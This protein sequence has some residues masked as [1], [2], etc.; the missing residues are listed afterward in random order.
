MRR[1]LGDGHRRGGPGGLRLPAHAAAPPQQAPARAAAG[2]EAGCV[3]GAL[4]GVWAVPG[5][6]G[7]R[8]VFRAVLT[9]N[10]A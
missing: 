10:G 9:D 7:T 6:D 3:A 1:G 4:E 2:G 8:R 5:A